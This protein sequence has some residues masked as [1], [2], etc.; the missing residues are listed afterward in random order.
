MANNLNN[1]SAVTDTDKSV[2]RAIIREGLWSN[3]PALVQLLGLCP[4]L[5]VSNTFANSLG[6]GVVTLVV[7]TCSN[8]LISSLRGQ[9]DGNTRLPAQILIIAT[10]VTCA[11]LLLQSYFYGLH[12]R[13][14]LFVALIVTNCTLLA[15]AESYASRQPLR[16]AALDGLMM[17]LGFALVLVILGAIRE[18]LGK[19]TLFADMHLLFGEA[20]REWRINLG[21]DGFLLAIL[22]PG[23]FISF[24]CL[25]AIYNWIQQRGENKQATTTPTLTETAAQA[26]LTPESDPNKPTTIKLI[27]R[28]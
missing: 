26:K 22:P 17:G 15:R 19:G 4:L 14:G 12:Q 8:L 23:A 21:Y 20:A 27:H 11:D 9:L 28:E 3:N 1:D 10:F 24:G 16:Y 18:I 25:I 2:A 5:A 7:L 6:L 13:I